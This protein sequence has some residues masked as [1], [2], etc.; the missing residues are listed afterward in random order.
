MD[1]STVSA[2]SKFEELS[3]MLKLKQYIYLKNRAIKRLQQEKK[4]KL[5]PLTNV[6]HIISSI[7]PYLSKLQHSITSI[8]LLG[9]I[10]KT[11]CS[12]QINSRLLLSVPTTKVRRATDLSCHS[13]NY[14]LFHKYRTGCQSSS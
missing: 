4:A 13:S 10:G 11:E 7:Q 3:L 8:Q 2:P 6:K 14:L 5:T 9:S 12:L 1:V